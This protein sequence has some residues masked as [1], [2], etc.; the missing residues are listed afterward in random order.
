MLQ[1]YK[2]EKCVDVQKLKL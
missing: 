1:V 2:D